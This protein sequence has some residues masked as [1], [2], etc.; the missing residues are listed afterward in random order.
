MIK[1]KN[2]RLALS[3]KSAVCGSKKSRFMKEQEPKE[4]FSNLGI[5]APLSKVSLLSILL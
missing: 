4:L 3:S 5:K 2:G 1:T